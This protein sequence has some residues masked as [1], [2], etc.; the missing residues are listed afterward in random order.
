VAAPLIISVVALAVAASHS[1]AGVAAGDCTADASLDSEEQAFLTL[2]NNHRAQNGRAPLSAS[3]KLSKASQWKST[4]MGE[5]HYFAHDDLSRSWVQRIRDCGYSYNTYL[6]ENIAAGNSSALATFNQWKNSSGHNANMLSTSY[7]AVGIGRAFVSGSPYGWY[8]TTDFGGIADP[9]PNA[10]PTHSPTRTPTNTP[11]RTPTN[12]P[13]RTP[14]PTHTLTPDITTPSLTINA[15]TAGTTLSG[16]VTISVSAQDAG[17][18]HKVRAWVGS[19]YLGYDQSAPYA[20]PWNTSTYPN[21]RH[22][23]RAQALDLAGNS[24][25]K[26]IIVT[27]INPDSAPPSV[28]ITAPADG[29]TVSGTIALAANA[30]DAEGMQKVRFWADGAYLGYDVSPPYTVNWNSAAAANG[31]RVIRAEAV[32]WVNHTTSV[33]VTINVAN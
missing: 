31:P 5:N 33:T 32:D 19:T 10:T 1:P 7:T 20:W 21:G 4:D 29:A 16:N 23:I 6:G 9:W 22:T 11:T 25:I 2:I 28:A 26:T 27:V 3:F 30:S 8:W 18:M 17:G 13:T 24:T 12:T 15:P 14:T